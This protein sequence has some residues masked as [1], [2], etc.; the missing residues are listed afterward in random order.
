LSPPVIALPASALTTTTPWEPIVEAYLDAAI[1]SP[2]TRRAYSRHL[3]KAFAV[4]GIW[5]VGELA[6]ADLARYRASVISSD[7]APGSQAQALAALRSFL[8][9]SRTLGA[10]RL[11]GEVIRI[12]LKTPKVVV[13]RPYRTLGEGDIASVLATA[14]TS[15]DRALL[16]VLLGGGLRAAEA[17]GLD[18]TDLHD[19][20]DGGLVIAVR[21]GKG[22]RDRQVPVQPEV[23][24]LLLGYLAETGRRLGDLGPLFRAHDRGHHLRGRVRLST[25]A[26]GYLVRKAMEKAGLSAKAI[27]PHALRHTYAIRALRAGGNVIAVQK[28]LGHASVATTQRYLDHLALGELR[29]AVPPLP[30]LGS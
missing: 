1:D 16:G 28:L 9:W 23:S 6:G 27:S 29:A 26:V 3:H 15:R 10:H 24:S 18:V 2:H 11:P 30:V 12:A 8:S 4:L 20:P 7:L 22:R 21:R 17:V 13:R 5:T 14:A 25:R 19:D